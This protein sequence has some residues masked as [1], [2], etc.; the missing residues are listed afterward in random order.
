M[1]FGRWSLILRVLLIAVPLP[2][3]AFGQGNMPTTQPPVSASEMMR[4]LSQGPVNYQVREEQAP[5]TIKQVLSNL[6]AQISAKQ[7]KFDVAYTTALDVPLKMLAGT[8]IPREPNVAPAVNKRAELLS[9]ADVESAKQSKVA[10]PRSP[11]TACS[12]QASHFDWRAQSKVTPVR[13]QICG[14]CWDFA[15]MG[16]Y[17]GSYAIRNNKLVDTS[18]QYILNCAN[19]GNC[20]GGWWMPVF[21]YLMPHGDASAADDPITGNDQLSCPPNKKTPYQASAWGFVANDQWAIPS[22]TSVKQALCEHG[23]LVTAVFV[24]LAFQAYSNGTF[25]EH[26]QQFNGVNHGIVIIGWDD[27]RN[28]WLIKNSW[29]SGWGESGFMWIAYD[30]NNIGIAT[31]WVDAK[32]DSYSLIDD[33]LQR[34]Q[35]MPVKAPPLPNR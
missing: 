3:V 4:I 26:T 12:P 23:P 2:A 9:E 19:A 34:L 1:S 33:W 5:L 11:A 32:S 30:T 29:G 18:E 22:V 35:Q 8:I 7:A 24:D 20:G 21:D 6:R 17:E 16:A 15:A 25:D 27:S 10:I 13:T 14:T 31:A 28:A